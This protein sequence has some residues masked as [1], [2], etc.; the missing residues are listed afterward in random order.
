MPHQDWNGG[1]PSDGLTVLSEVERR[2]PYLLRPESPTREKCVKSLPFEAKIRR[3]TG[4]ERG[5]VRQIADHMKDVLE[6]LRKW[7]VENGRAGRS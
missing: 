5:Q 7:C 2:P 3:M 4:M 6:G 1:L